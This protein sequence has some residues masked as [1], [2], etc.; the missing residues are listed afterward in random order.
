MLIKIQE[1]F[2]KLMQMKPDDI[3]DKVAKEQEEIAKGV[4]SGD[5]KIWHRVLMGIMILFVGIFLVGSVFFNFLLDM[6]AARLQEGIPI[7]HSKANQKLP[8]GEYHL[9]GIVHNGDSME[10]LQ[11]LYFLVSSAEGGAVVAVKAPAGTQLPEDFSVPTDY[12]IEVE[13]DG[14]WKIRMTAE[15][16]RKPKT[17]AAK[18]AQESEPSSTATK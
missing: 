9:Y 11:N 6:Q 12:K 16:R 17:A 18:P 2:K 10:E 7:V 3:K 4:A 5:P 15:A 8:E 1:K 13:E 14:A